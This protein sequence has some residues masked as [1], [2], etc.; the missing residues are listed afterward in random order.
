MTMEYTTT[1]RDR[2]NHAAKMISE[3]N[4]KEAYEVLQQAMNETSCFAGQFA[5]CDK[6]HKSFN[7]IAYT[8]GDVSRITNANDAMFIWPLISLPS[9]QADEDQLG[10]LSAVCAVSLFNM[11]LACHLSSQEQNSSLAKKKH[12]LAQAESLYLQAFEVGTYFEIGILNVALFI[13]L[14]DISFERGDLTALPFWTNSLK[15]LAKR[16]PSDL[17]LEVWAMIWKAD[18]YFGIGLISARAA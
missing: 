5:G 11:G 12:L 3:G 6:K 15:L 4:R 9:G 14:M 1:L 13:N 2:N 16:L 17:Q 18:L 8:T 10:S 7:V